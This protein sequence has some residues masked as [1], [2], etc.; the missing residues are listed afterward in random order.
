MAPAAAVGQGKD[1]PREPRLWGCPERYFREVLAPVCC[2]SPCDVLRSIHF[3]VVNPFCLNSWGG[4]SF[5]QL[6][7]D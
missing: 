7:P 1:P 6:S 3:L 2:S 4:F 5:Q